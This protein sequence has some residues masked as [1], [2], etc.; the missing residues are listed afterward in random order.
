MNGIKITFNDGTP[1]MF[2]SVNRCCAYFSLQLAKNVNHNNIMHA[3]ADINYARSFLKLPNLDT[4]TIFKPEI[5]VPKMW[6]CDVCKV[7]MLNTS[8]L[9]HVNSIDH[10]INFN[11]E[12]QP[13]ISKMKEGGDTLPI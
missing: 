1:L 3:I 2:N 12:K 5:H 8:R 11:F 10:S 7:E 4:I 13:I 9:N 6:Y